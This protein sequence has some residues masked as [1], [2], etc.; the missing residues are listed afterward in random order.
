MNLFGDEEIICDDNPPETAV[1]DSLSHPKEMPYCLGHGRQEELF[2]ELF[3]KDKLPHAMIFSGEQGVGK[4]T[5]AFRLAR[6]LLKHGHAIDKNQDSL[7]G[8]GDGYMGDMQADISSLDVA[9]DDPVFSRIAS[10]GHAD[11]LYIH[12]HYDSTKNK[13]DANLKVE[14]LRKIEPFLRKTSSQGGWRIVIIDD[15]DTMN[16]NAQNAIL[17]ILEEPPANVLIIL[18]THRIGMLIPTIRS[19]AR[20]VAFDSLSHDIMNE[21]L[22]K[23]GYSLSFSEIETLGAL[24]KGSIGRALHFAEEGGLETLSLIMEHLDDAPNWNWAKIHPLSTSLA[25]PAQDK[26]YRMFAE[27]L[28]W[29]FRQ[30]LFA[31]AR[32][33]QSLPHYIQNDSLQKIMNDYSLEKL[34][35]ISDNLKNHFERVDFSNLDRRD[36][37]R[38]AFLV[39][40]Q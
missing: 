28:Q 38:G 39:I 20:N 17:K 35:S 14:A 36:A 12:R 29:V 33:G 5:M 11:L 37:V 22:N 32:A 18:I 7:F 21:L 30:I 31:K 23:Q 15:A 2:L 8:G 34:I 6:F 25:T 16:R 26:E 3:K 27:L 19:R 24:S 4:S 10:G 9:A 40:D 13:L 1:S